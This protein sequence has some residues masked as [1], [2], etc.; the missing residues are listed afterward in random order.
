MATLI[1]AA[2]RYTIRITVDADDGAQTTW[3]HDEWA[4][5]GEAALHIARRAV[6]RDHPDSPAFELEIVGSSDDLR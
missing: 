2:K 1:P 3:L 5:D 6:R 4:T